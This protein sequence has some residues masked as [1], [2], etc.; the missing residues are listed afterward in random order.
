MKTTWRCTNSLFHPNRSNSQPRLWVYDDVIS[1]CL[2]IV[3]TSSITH[4][5]E[6]TPSL[7]A[8]I[9]SLPDGPVENTQAI[10]K[11][12]VFRNTNAEKAYKIILPS[13]LMGA[14]LDAIPSCIYKKCLLDSHNIFWANKWSFTSRYLS[15]FLQSSPSN[16][17]L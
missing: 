4:F 3:S 6:V 2:T 15:W 7:N 16:I 14:F 1:D 17:Y 9:P 11:Y 13:K 8:N 12:F 10:S 5:A